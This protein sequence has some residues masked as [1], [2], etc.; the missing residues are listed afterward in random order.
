[1]TQE[2][3]GRDPATSQP[4]TGVLRRGMLKFGTLLTAFTGASAISAIGASSAQA[5]L[6][7]VTPTTAYVPVS[8]KGAPLGV[9]TLDMESKVPLAQLPDLSATIDAQMQG[10]VGNGSSGF[11]NALVAWFKT[12]FPLKQDLGLNILDFGVVRGTSTSQTAA[13]K[14][15]LDA[16]P[17]EDFYFPRGDYRLDTGLVISQANSLNLAPRARLYAGAP[18]PTLI[19]YLWSGSGYAEDK[20]ITGGL[21][22]GNLLANRILSIGKVIRFTL[23]R[24]TFKNGINRGLVTEAGLGAEVLAYDLRFHNT[25]VTNVADNIAIEA[26]M[27]D[28]HFRDII[29]RDWTT[30]VKDTAFNRWDRVH[31]WISQ[32]QGAATHMT[33][34]YPMSIGFD[35]T[36]NSDVQ[37]CVADT[38]RIAYKIR[39]NGTNYTSPP[40]LL[41]AR[42]MWAN[43]P[44][45]PTALAT[46]N[47]AYVLDNTD[48]VG[49]ICDR[50]TATGHSTVPGNFLTGPATNLTTRNTYSYGYI[51]GN[52]GSTAD[53][54]DYRNGILNGTFTFAPVLRG[55]TG[56]GK[57][58]YTTQVGRMLVE[59]DRVTYWFRV[60]ATLDSTT[61]LAGSL[62]ITGMSLPNGATNIRDAAG[63][64]GLVT[65]TNIATCAVFSGTS[66]TV[67]PYILGPSRVIEVDTS[68]LRG[69]TIEIMGT[70][71]ATHFKA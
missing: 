43:D 64:V 48:G 34:R 28:S 46:A 69:K 8:E 53:P 19:T 21:L 38:Y 52:T 10:S 2:A 17:G 16:N 36:G 11:W 23:T 26:K 58:T 71:T 54:L 49:A 24:T 14:A 66:V 3:E 41:N 63:T 12:L 67:V 5:A 9:P 59:G 1:M 4:E 62:R 30:A 27:G 25:G 7:D 65:G 29:I 33:S 35:L 32:V 47:P 51:R 40:R 55:L 42:A 50:L 18:M 39:S 15:A 44:I 45:L 57:H 20:A 37:A 22:D 13:I 6:G 56:A 31:P 61:A 60:R 68:A 70:I